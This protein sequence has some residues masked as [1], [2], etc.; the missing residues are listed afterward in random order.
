MNVT[1]FSLDVGGGRSLDVAPRRARRRGRRR[2]APRDAGLRAARS[3]PFVEAA[4]GARAPAGLVLP[5]RLC[6]LQPPRGPI[7]SP[8]A[9]RTSSRIVDHLGVDRF[10]TMG[11]SGGGPHT[12]ACAALL[13]ERV[14]ACATV[15]GVGPWGAEGLDF[16]EGMAPEN[17]RG[18]RCGRSRARMRCGRTSSLRPTKLADVTGDQVAAALG[19]LVSRVDRRRRTGEFAEYAGRDV[20]RCGSRPGSG[21]GSTTTSPSRVRGGSTCRRSGFR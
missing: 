16:L 6:G 9:S 17:H 1:E 15:A 21:V 5:P 10:A 11:W 12:L 20:P 4:S 14:I 3:A 13:P 19:G 18:V 7:A 8:I 2:R